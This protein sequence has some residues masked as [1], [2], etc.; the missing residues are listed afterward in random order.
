MKNL[1][2][3]VKVYSPGYQAIDW[4][5][6]YPQ[7]VSLEEAL[8]QPTKIAVL[9]VYYNN[10]RD[11]AYKSEFEGLNLEPFDLVIFHD[12]EFRR[13]TDLINWI[14]TTGARN[15]L[16]CVGGLHANETL[17]SRTV[18]RPT[19]SFTFLQWNPTRE[20]FPLERP[21]LFDCLCGTRRE[22]RD[23]AMLALEK[24]GLLDR[25]IATYRDIFLGTN[26]TETP[27]RVKNKFP[28]QRLT[29][30]YVSP[31]L[32]PAW[33]VREKLDNSISSIVP[34]E[35]F[36]RCYYSMLVETL[37]VGDCYLMAEK[38]GKCLHA[39]R[40]F[41]HFGVANWLQQLREFGFQTFNN[42]LDESYDGIKDDINRWHAAFE[43]VQWLSRQD[44]A[45]IL[46]KAKPILDHNHRRLYEFREEKFNEMRHLI[47]LHLR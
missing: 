31:N 39:R 40:L 26:L 19:W 23:Y 14:N 16:L 7:V 42:I 25:S 28:G 1:Y 2:P 24:S 6:D 46:Q 47:E 22:H 45:Q 21:F 36:N 11:F 8:S 32:D 34:W 30:P 44:P 4:G 12:I 3:D 33:E 5:F 15:W 27:Q 38:I 9:P 41:V 18:Y 17:D 35:I 43:Q 13:Q 29:W 20:D 37:G 10:P